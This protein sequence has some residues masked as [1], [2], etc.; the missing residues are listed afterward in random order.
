VS[1]A[2][3]AS[4]NDEHEDDGESCDHGESFHG[5]GGSGRSASLLG[6]HVAMKSRNDWR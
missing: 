1:S 4:C 3:V 6:V 5:S 2:V